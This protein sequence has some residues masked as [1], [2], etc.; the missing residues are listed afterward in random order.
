MSEQA[1]AIKRARLRKTPVDGATLTYISAG[2]V[3]RLTGRREMHRTALEQGGY[4]DAP[5]AEVEYKDFW[6]RSYTGWTYAGWLE[7]VSPA[8]PV[9]PIDEVVRIP[10]ELRTPDPNDAQQYL[11]IDG[12][13]LHNLCP[14]FCAAFVGGDAIDVF[15]AKAAERSP[16]NWA[17][18]VRQDSGLGISALEVLLRD[19]YGFEMERFAEGLRDDV[20]GTL[21][22]PG[23]LREK[24]DS[25]WLLIA[26]VK[27]TNGGK[28]TNGGRIGHWV[29]VTDVQ[30]YGVRDGQVRIYNPFPNQMRTYTYGELIASMS[31]WDGGV[32]TGVWVPNDLARIPSELPQKGNGNVLVSAALDS[33]IQQVDDFVAEQREWLDVLDVWMKR[34]KA[35]LDELEKSLE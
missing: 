19:V 20:V 29:V 18:N 24:L 9:A 10:D 17:A 8:A 22:S 6:K 11:R 25:G 34:Q 35:T 16:A 23:K 3:L 7:T 32:M 12:K 27:I 33:L 14:S 30:P 4:A 2:S 5:W 15:L 1:Y 26:G 28:L 21:V 31:A 13:D